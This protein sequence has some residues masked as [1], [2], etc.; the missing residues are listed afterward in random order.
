M[1]IYIRLTK[2]EEIVPYE[3][4]AVLTG[5]LNKWLNDS[6]IHD[7][8]SLYSFSGLRKG[9]TSKKGLDFPEGGEWFVSIYDSHILLKVLK[10]IQEN[11]D[12]AYGMKVKEVTLCEYPAF[13][14]EWR[15][16]LATP[17][18]IKRTVGNKCVHYI[19]Q[20]EG[21][22]ELMTETLKRKMKSVGLDDSSVSVM[23]DKTYV[24]AKVKLMSYKGIKNKVNWC[25]VRISGTP[26]SIRFAWDVGIGNS[27]GIGFGTLL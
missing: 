1:R 21:S 23:F 11:A 2:N 27:T 25:P 14:Y 10:R 17:I 8:L 9:L 4:N 26:E 19:Y 24:R 5:I 18:L 16:R 20:N 22:N 3:H 13:G 15:F 6:D 12:F 7:S